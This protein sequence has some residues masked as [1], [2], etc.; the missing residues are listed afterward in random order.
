MM[1]DVGCTF[2]PPGF[3]R[4]VIPL[5]MLMVAVVGMCMTKHALIFMV[6]PTIRFKAP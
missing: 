3:E 1:N 5:K 4:D 6:I 2:A